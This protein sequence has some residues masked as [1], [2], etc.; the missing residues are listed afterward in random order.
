M[1]A[2]QYLLHRVHSQL[3]IVDVQQKLVPVIPQATELLETTAFLLT[4]AQIM[5]VPVVVSEQYPKGLGPTVSEISEH[6]IQKTVFE[7]LKFSAA[8]GF[9]QSGSAE[10]HQTRNQI[11]ITGIET[12]ICVLQTAIDL[13][14]AG[15]QVFVVQ[16]A[17]GSRHAADQA[18]AL[19]RIRNAGVTVCCAESV[20]FEWCEAAGTDEFRQISR[21]VRERD[22]KRT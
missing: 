10:S 13:L 2:T 5:N 12:H 22:A 3:L 21:L 9:L 17:V 15:M 4:A 18:S 14:S 19:D 8:D 16:D 7:K 11:V 6:R 1:A 20:V